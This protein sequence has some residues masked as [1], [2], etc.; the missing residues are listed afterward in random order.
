MECANPRGFD[1]PSLRRQ[2][3]LKSA[4]FVTKNSVKLRKVRDFAS[5]G[6]YSRKSGGI[7]VTSSLKVHALIELVRNRS[8]FP[9]VRGS[10]INSFRPANGFS[11]EKRRLFSSGLEAI[12]VNSTRGIQVLARQCL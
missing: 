9:S 4:P 7:I 12:V 3:E 10:S 11:A 5:I 6:R 8:L 1:A 2:A